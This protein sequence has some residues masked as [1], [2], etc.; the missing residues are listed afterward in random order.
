MLDG[1]LACTARH[2]LKTWRLG[3]ALPAETS[4]SRLP[5]PDPVGHG[6]HAPAHEIGLVPESC[7][8]GIAQELPPPCLGWWLSAPITPARQLRA[9]QLPHAGM[10]RNENAEGFV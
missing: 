9:R 6:L 2:A 4:E 3:Q 7:A 8:A 10:R 1:I 5:S